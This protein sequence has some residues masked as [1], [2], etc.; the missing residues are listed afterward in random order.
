MD[1][2]TTL[3]YPRTESYYAVDTP[4]KYWRVYSGDTCSPNSG[5]PEGKNMR[6][7]EMT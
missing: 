6:I 1:S 2:T 3:Q 5:R 7:Q 4:Y